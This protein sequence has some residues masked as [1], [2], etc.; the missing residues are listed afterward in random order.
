MDDNEH[1]EDDPDAGLVFRPITAVGPLGENCDT[2]LL[3][4][5]DTCADSTPF[6]AVFRQVDLRPGLCHSRPT[7]GPTVAPSQPSTAP[8]LAPSGF[9]WPPTTAPVSQ[10]TRVTH[11]PSATP[12]VAKTSASITEDNLT[13][14]P[15]SDVAFVKEKEGKS[16]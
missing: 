6:Q 13:A 10:P 5:T 4:A 11:A 3:Q 14:S 8:S 9:S 7:L 12:T 15:G 2:T 1:L 16:L